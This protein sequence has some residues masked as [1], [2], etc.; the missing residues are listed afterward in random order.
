MRYNTL[1]LFWVLAAT[2]LLVVA[3]F[4]GCSRDRETLSYDDLEAK[5][6]TASAVHQR[7]GKLFDSL[8]KLT[9]T[10]EPDSLLLER[11]FVATDEVVNDIAEFPRTLN[12]RLA[13]DALSYA[14]SDLANSPALRKPV[15]R[16]YWRIGLLE[17]I[18][19]KSRVYIRGD[20]YNESSQLQLVK[21]IQRG[22]GSKVTDELLLE[23]IP[24]VGPAPSD[25]LFAICAADSLALRRI[26]DLLLYSR[27]LQDIGPPLW[28]VTGDWLMVADIDGWPPAFYGLR[29]QMIDDL[30]YTTFREYS[31]GT[32]YEKVYRDSLPSAPAERD[33]WL[34][35]A[36]ACL[37][38]LVIDADFATR[39]Q[40]SGL[41][42]Y[43]AHN[44]YNDYMVA[45]Y[46]DS[47]NKRFE[48]V[49]KRQSLNQSSLQFTGIDSTGV[50]FELEQI[51]EPGIPV[52]VMNAHRYRGGS[53]NNGQYI[54]PQSG[55]GKAYL[56]PLGKH[57]PMKLQA[58]LD[59]QQPV[60]QVNTTPPR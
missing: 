14:A 28:M 32:V 22:A 42:L 13:L 44:I 30:L 50:V 38:S 35:R 56:M 27:S 48:L 51:V 15:I 36:A 47:V 59:A 12:S 10:D 24:L 4:A 41:P 23:L 11:V 52:T 54:P 43:D 6:G 49:F 25:S 5:G 2:S 55:T 26:H 16:N 60:I 53:M 7:Y 33:A 17:P 45:A 9:E 40:G 20:R 19:I 37:D 58:L 46:G 34:K 8:T 21:A 18:L 1:R 39:A 31:P 29:T 3:L 57:D